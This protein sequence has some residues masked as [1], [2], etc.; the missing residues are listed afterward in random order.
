MTFFSHRLYFV[1]LLPVSTVSYL[2]YNYIYD[3]VTLI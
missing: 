1:C 3:Y 2:I